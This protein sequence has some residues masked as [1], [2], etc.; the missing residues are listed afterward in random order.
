LIIDG[1]ARALVDGAHIISLSLG[2]TNGWSE[3][4]GT[5]I[6]NRVA[7][8]GVFMSIAAGNEGD[9]GLFT[10]SAPAAGVNSMAIASV[11]SISVVAWNALS[12]NRT[13][14]NLK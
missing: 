6:A 7:E 8:R 4:P 14:V 2:G 11:D 12:G 1:I 9:V 10:A 3:D 13:T 5:V